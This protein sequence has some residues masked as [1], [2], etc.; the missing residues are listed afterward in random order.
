MPDYQKAKNEKK[1]LAYYLTVFKTEN[2]RTYHAVLSN[3]TGGFDRQIKGTT[4]GGAKLPEI[5]V[6]KVYKVDRISGKVVEIML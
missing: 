5:T 2:H 4:A 1:D 6:K 3:D